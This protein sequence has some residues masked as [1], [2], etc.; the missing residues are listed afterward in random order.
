MT[1]THTYTHAFTHTHMSTLGGQS[2]WEQTRYPFHVD[3]KHT[4]W[5]WMN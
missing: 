5:W 1:M 4:E 3:I 2:G